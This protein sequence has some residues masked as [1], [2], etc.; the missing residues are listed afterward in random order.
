MAKYKPVGTVWK[1]K[2]S[3]WPAVIAVVIFFI[4]IGAVFG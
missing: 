4:I 3:S 2:E 1:K